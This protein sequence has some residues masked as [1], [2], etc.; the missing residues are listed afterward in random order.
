[1]VIFFTIFR[2]LNLKS[3][4]LH[5]DCKNSSN[6]K[7]PQN[8]LRQYIL[9]I[10]IFVAPF[11]GFAQEVDSVI[12]K[13]DSIID[14]SIKVDSSKFIQDSTLTN[15]SDSTKTAATDSVKSKKKGDI[16][17]TVNYNAK[18]SLNFN[19]KTQDIIMYKNAH[20]DYGDIELEA[21]KI[22]VNYNTK[23]LDASGLQDTA[24]KITGEPVFT[25]KGQ[26]Y[27]TEKITYNFDTKKA[28]IKGVV[29]QQGEAFMH[30]NWT[31]KNEKDEMFSDH[32]LYTTCNL[33][34]PHFGI[35]ANKIKLIPGDKILAGP[36]N[37]EITELPTPFLFPFGMFP[38]PN[39]K[40]S[41][42]LFPTYGEENRRGFFL[43]DGGYYWAIN[44][45][46]DMALRGEI[47]SKGSYGL[48]VASNYKKDTAIMEI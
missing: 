39:N 47:Y 42:I 32:A 46:A 43:R 15:L 36:F 48:S 29:T 37:L 22:K 24:G 5:K 4:I 27:Q 38:M 17:T 30:S 1:M 31:K 45:Y 33:E 10:F 20:V 16:A 40:T 26:V 18:D 23:I 35:S 9:S 25:D 34:H 7:N 13:S 14:S 21:D 2:L 44:D 28:I 3:I 8:N 41:G 19:L 12:Q 6:R 11:L